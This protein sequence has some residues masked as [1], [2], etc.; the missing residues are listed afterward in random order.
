MLLI[1]F[2]VRSLLRSG[3]GVDRHRDPLTDGGVC[4]LAARLEAVRL[5]VP[6]S[7]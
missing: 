6:R 5:P 7:H 1:Q 4:A 3:A 2:Y